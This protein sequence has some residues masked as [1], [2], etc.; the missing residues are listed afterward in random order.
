[1]RENDENK[2]ILPQN[3]NTELQN[4]VT[5]T[6]KRE[7]LL[8]DNPDDSNTIIDN[9]I[10]NSV[11]NEIKLNENTKV[12]VSEVDAD[13]DDK[14]F[15]DAMRSKSQLAILK[16]SNQM[17]CMIPLT[18]AENIL[19]KMGGNLEED[20][21]A[22]AFG[23]YSLEEINEIRKS[24]VIDKQPKIFINFN[25]DFNIIMPPIERLPR[26]NKQLNNILFKNVQ[27]KID[28][29]KAEE[30][31]KKRE[32]EEK[33]KKIEEINRLKLLEK[34]KRKEKVCNK[35]KKIRND[36]RLEILKKKFNQYRNNCEELRIME[37]RKKIET[38]KK[39]LR[40]KIKRDSNNPEDNQDLGEVKENDGKKEKNEEIE[41][42][43]KIYE[44]EK[45][46][47]EKKGKKEENKLKNEKEEEGEQLKR[48]KKETDRLKE[49][50]ED[51][52]K[53]EEGDK[54]KKEEEKL[55]KMKEEKRKKEEEKKKK[56]EEEQKKKEEEE[57]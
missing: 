15:I 31:R 27:G 40:L 13:A 46:K 24:M 6:T 12:N 54:L 33:R 23:I 34:E 10:S 30:E 8:K 39:V 16:D 25:K 53:E 56:E 36:N 42:E 45:K 11:K 4:E 41:K 29:I 44:K 49:E 19:K 35:L 21:S 32:E 55:R 26:N 47:E 50:A 14:K 52:L 22:F 28:F 3:G 17:I 48:E 7:T 37:Q 9:I 20:F 2:R 5:L 43:Q 51:R 57:R 18:A 1:M 38:E